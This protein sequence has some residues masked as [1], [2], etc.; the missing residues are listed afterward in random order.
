MLIRD[1]IAADAYG[2]ARVHVHSWQ[3]AYR[4]L[5]PQDVLDR[6]SID[7]RAERWVGILTKPEPSSRTLVLENDGEILAWT[8]FGAAR[9]DAP[10]ATGELWGVYAHPDSWSAGVGHSI[11]AAVEDALRDAGHRS[12]YLWVLDGNERAARFYERHGWIEDGGTKLDERPE[13]NLHERR[14]VKRLTL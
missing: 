10:A 4:G 7:D 1:A 11:L 3:R 6:L 2:I 13:M 14:R 5:M 12:A 9:D 8:S